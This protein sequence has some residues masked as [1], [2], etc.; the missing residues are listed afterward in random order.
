MVVLVTGGLF[1]RSGQF[2]PVLVN[3]SASYLDFPM[4]SL[5]DALGA[6]R[7]PGYPLLLRSVV[8]VTGSRSAIP[9]VQFL[10]YA[11]AVG[12]FFEAL[13]RWT[14]RGWMSLAVALSL[15]SAPILTEYVATI[16]TDTLAGALGIAAGAL[17]ILWAE[18]QQTR[19]LVGLGVSL[20][21]GWLVRPVGVFLIPWSLLLGWKLLEER[22]HR[23]ADAPL[24]APL[25]SLAAVVLGPLLVW[26]GFRGV[27]LGTWGVASFEGYNLIGLAGQFVREETIAR[28]EPEQQTV[29]RQALANRAAREA[30]GGWH[31]AEPPLHYLRMEYNHDPTI[32]NDYVPPARE[33]VGESTLAVNGFLSSL[34]RSILRSQPDDYCIWLAKATREAARKI[35]SDLFRHPAP[36]ALL[37]SGAALFLAN[38]LTR[39][40]GADVGESST[41][42]LVRLL[43]MM[44]TSY[45]VLNLAC[46]IPF[47]PPRER[48]TDAAAVWGPA[49]LAAIVLHAWAGIRRRE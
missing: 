9:V 21:A 38:P 18:S 31:L 7:T 34:A 16:A 6:V 24:R 29:V 27:W 12:L 22:R 43:A 41:E 30:Q 11:A 23:R 25:L 49:V 48:M 47:V 33:A 32:W 45:A 20:A 36:L 2:S 8:A 4:T 42:T 40:G 3:D 14:G 10:C 1:F 35:F 39:A 28:L 26:V 13:S 19:H 46:T 5:T 15:L 44:A 37:L 17:L